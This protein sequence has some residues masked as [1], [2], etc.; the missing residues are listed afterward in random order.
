M[1]L[2]YCFAGS[3]IKARWHVAFWE[4][5]GAPSR[6]P[7]HLHNVA[8]CHMETGIT[9]LCLSLVARCPCYPP[10]YP[11]FVSFLLLYACFS[12]AF[13]SFVAVFRLSCVVFCKEEG[14]AL[15]FFV[16]M[17]EIITVGNMKQDF[18]RTTETHRASGVPRGSACQHQLWG[19]RWQREGLILMW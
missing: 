11:N 3:D 1:P 9:N 18:R 8:T 5:S 6:L 13:H 7:V 10:S 4:R 19:S 14:A 16:N 17:V 15:F 12:P 2:T